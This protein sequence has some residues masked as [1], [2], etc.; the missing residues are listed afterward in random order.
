MLTQK[1]IRVGNSK[2]VVIPADFIHAVGVK[3]GD[4]V[5]VEANLTTGKV[6]Y[7]FRGIRQL[8]LMDKK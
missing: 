5:K 2:A 6:T 7:T 3:K 4:F 8:P 1:V